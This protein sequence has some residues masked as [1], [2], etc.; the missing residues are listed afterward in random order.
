MMKNIK[1]FLFLCAFIF[2]IPCVYPQTD[3]IFSSITITEIETL[4]ID[5]GNNVLKKEII[6]ANIFPDTAPYQWI[7]YRMKVNME[8]ENTKRAFQIYYVN[9]IDS[10]IYINVHISG[11]ELVRIV[12]TP[13]QVTFVNKLEYE[14][15]EGGFEFFKAYI[16]IPLNFN[17]FQALFS[18]LDFKEFEKNHL[19][20]DFITNIQLLAIERCNPNLS[21]EILCLHQEVLLDNHFQVTKN[22]ITIP[23]FNKSLLIDYQNYTPTPFGSFFNMISIHIPSEKMKLNGELKSV[24]FDVPGPTSIKIPDSFSRILLPEISPQ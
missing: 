2:S 24:K 7:S 6:P 15:Y 9:K 12:M 17:M 8:K 23:D 14:Y 18:A 13:E 4:Q 1:S 16:G 19:I 5:T 11:I 3:T 20:T 22:H 21:S 10:I